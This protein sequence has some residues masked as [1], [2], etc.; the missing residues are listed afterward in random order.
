MLLE[1]GVWGKEVT[2]TVGEDGGIGSYPDS[3]AFSSHWG[4]RTEKAWALR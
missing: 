3:S 4:L 2:V 1:W